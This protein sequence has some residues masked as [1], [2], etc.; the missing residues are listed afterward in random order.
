MNQLARLFAALVLSP[1]FG[2]SLSSASCAQGAPGG[3][4]EETIVRALDEEERQAVLAGDTAA[5]EGLWSEALIVNNPQS[6]VSVSRGDV[7][8]L[9]KRGLIR[10]AT[11]ERRV[12]EVRRNGDVVV[13]MGTESVVPAG[14]A[15]LAGQTVQRRFTNVWM[16]EEGTWRMIAR[17]ANVVPSN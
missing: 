9:V 13:V 12:E 8:D 11:F 15:P 2:V 3:A 10:Y 16:K 14:D 7:L 17:H 5:L 4:A 1:L 6:R